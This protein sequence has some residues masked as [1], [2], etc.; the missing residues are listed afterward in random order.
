MEFKV[1][2]IF[3]FRKCILLKIW[4]IVWKWDMLFYMICGFNVME[5]IR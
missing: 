1:D 3:K 5:V 2:V 4:Y